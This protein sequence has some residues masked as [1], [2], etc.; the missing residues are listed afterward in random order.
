MLAVAGLVVAGIV[1]F[2]FV[3]ASSCSPEEPLTKPE[4]LAAALA[5][6]DAGEREAART[7]ARRLQLLPDL[8][9]AEQ[10]IPLYL[11]G[12]AAAA[13]AEAAEEPAER[14]TLQLLAAHYL[15][16]ALA[17]H[18]PPERAGPGWLTRG[19]C[20]L[21]TG[22]PAEAAR[23]LRQALDTAPQEQAEICLL[24]ARAH[25]RQIPADL[26]KARLYAERLLTLPELDPALRH[27]GLLEL[28]DGQVR[29]GDFTAAQATAEQVPPNSPSFPAARVLVAEVLLREAEKLLAAKTPDPASASAAAD[30]LKAAIR[31]LR[32]VLGR[33]DSEPVSGPAELLLGFCLRDE[34]GLAE[35]ADRAAVERQFVRTRKMHPHSP[36]AVAAWLEEADL[37]RQ[38]NRFDEAVRSYETVVREAGDPEMFGNRWLTAPVLQARLTAAFVALRDAG[39]ATAALDLAQRLPPF[40]PEWQTALLRAELLRQ[41]ATTAALAAESAT[42]PKRDDA[43]AEARARF[44]AAGQEFERLAR[45][46]FSERS[47]SDDLWS[48]TESFLRGHNFVRAARL[49]AEYLEHE[50]T[51]RRATALVGL[52]E[53]HVAAHRWDTAIAVLDACLGAYPRS[54]ES[55]RARLLAAEARLEQGDDADAQRR[56]EEN[57][58]GGAITPQSA[59]WRA[60]L[61]ALGRLVYRRALAAEAKSRTV[62]GRVDDPK[63]RQES[64]RDLERS[65]ELF[66]H[67]LR[68]LKEAATRYPNDEATYEAQFQIAESHR[69]RAKWPRR[70]LPTETIEATRHSWRREINRELLAAADEY[71]ALAERLNR[72]QEEG[73]L[74]VVEQAMLRNCYFA[75]AEA[76]FDLEKYDDAVQAYS[77]A[78]NRYLNEPVALEAFVQMASCYRRLK[79]PA[80]ARGQL[81]Q[82]RVVLTRLPADADFARTTRYDREGWN[83]YLQWLTNM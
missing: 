4:L 10:G 37:Q 1:A 49:L 77:A 6:W 31:E 56:L 71:R 53:C 35:N 40:V 59:E 22:Q 78:T 74:A 36:E 72:R 21:A 81:E 44:R 28:G 3:V 76:L 45:L 46:R 7:S 50:P 42:R 2:A 83:Q 14:R 65:Y 23:A 82:A 33:E 26:A 16:E 64:L 70:K 39:Q 69:L 66:G 54:P 43:W 30:R 13:D 5:E 57:L 8:T 55:Y 38:Q 60:S 62:G 18:L 52:G 80:E 75:R 24:L 41:L 63:L 20:L 29:A 79:K 9:F 48:A 27:Q 32:T 19:R 73:G 67:S 61:F 11:L 58:Y 34:A 17:R 51:R 47:F 12:M 25:A 15:D 68:L